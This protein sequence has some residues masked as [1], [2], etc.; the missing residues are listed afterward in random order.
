[1]AVLIDTS[2]SMSVK[3][4]PDGRLAQ[5][6]TWLKNTFMPAVPTSIDVSYYTFAQCSAP[7][8]LDSASPTGSVTALA[9]S[10]ENLL[11][12]PGDDPLLGVVVCSDGIESSARD[13]ETAAR[14]YRRRGIPLHTLAVGTTNDMHDIIVENVQVRRAVP[15]QA[16]TKLT[17]SVRAPGFAHQTVS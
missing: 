15:N 16:P 10:L 14:L 9:E 2:R 12:L 5:A 7:V 17:L 3:D 13:P 4:I 8:T 11:A 6:T 1:V